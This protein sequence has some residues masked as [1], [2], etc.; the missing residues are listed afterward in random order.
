MEGAQDSKQG[1]RQVSARQH[2]QN[3]LAVR[4][5]GVTRFGLS[6]AAIKDCLLP[7]SPVQELSNIVCFLDEA[8]ADAS[9]TIV[10]KHREIELLREYRTRLIADVVTGKLD[11]RDAAAELR[12]SILCADWDAS[13]TSLTESNPIQYVATTRLKRRQGHD[14]LDDLPGGGT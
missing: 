5:N 3:Q 2:R 1:R 6:P 11:V 14:E 4:A 9:Q 12:N 7:L 10:R 8:L 13:E